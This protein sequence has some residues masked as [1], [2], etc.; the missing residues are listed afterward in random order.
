MNSEPTTDTAPVEAPGAAPEPFVAV[1]MPLSAL[2]QKI[3]LHFPGL[4]VRKDLTNGLKQNAVVP[5]Y[6]LEYLLGQHCATDDNAV[7]KAGL[8]SVQK[9]LAKHYVH[10]NQ[11]QLVKSTIKEKGRHKVIDK[12]TVELNDKGGFYEA[13]FTNLG[14]K[15]VPVSDDFVRRFPKLLVGGIWCITDVTYEVAEDP[16]ASPWQIDTLKPIQ[17][18]SVDFEQFLKAR[19]QFSTEEWMDVLMQSMGFNPEMFGRR[20]KLLT[21]IRLIPYCERNY[22]LLE[23]GPKGTGKSHIYA[24]FSPHGMLISGSEVTAPKLF[25]SNASGKI[26]LVG[27]WDCVCFDE[28]AG[29]DKKVDKALVD[30]MKNYMANRT[31]SRGIEQLTAEASMVFMGNTKKSV[32]Y[33]LKHS[34]FFEPLPD[35]YIDSAFLD[36]I[37][38]YNPGWEVA[39]IRHELFTSGYGFVVDFIAEVLKHL[40]TE[41]FTGAYKKHFEITSEVSTRDQ[42]G[43]EKTFSGLMKILFPDGNATAR[44]VEE[45]LSFAMEARRRVREHILRIDDTFKR[46]DFIYRSL[47]GGAPVTVLTPEEI[48]YPTFA[49]P[50]VQKAAE[51]EVSPKSREETI[52]AVDS[53]PEKATANVV[54]EPQPGH[55]VVP[56][57]TKGWSYRRLFSKYLVGARRINI[58]DP[59]VRLFFQA[60]NLMEFLQMV[61]DLVPEGDEVAVH[62]K[63]QSDMDSCV[64]QEENLN[65]I[66]ESFIGSR[67]AFAWEF[68]HSPNFHARS[69]TTDTGWKITID[70]GLDIF[71]KY[72]S[73][74]FSLEQA[75]QETRLTRGAEITYLR[76]QK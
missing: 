19:A 37:H 13:E 14:L 59:Y 40:R 47:S 2:D 52:T 6:V 57:N 9:I 45:L 18:A 22:N 16:K 73:G 69:I 60:R 35:K 39:P 48:Q 3:L 43:F 8:E 74:P 27:Y 58:D 63:T 54:A 50:R 31:F 25:V 64:K 71:Q 28:F 26:G 76:L 10:R 24:E 23:L 30:I 41:D 29:K 5:T 65:Q 53:P 42:T 75:I 66:S 51:G 68:D 49:G 61:H 38:A 7:I 20:A 70:R 67:V 21:L 4:V 32:A 15:K 1:P 56:E 34:N 44:E 17:V 11:A 12:L 72:E 36:R 46:H 62:L 55:V 33:M